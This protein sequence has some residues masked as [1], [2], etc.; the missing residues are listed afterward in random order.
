MENTCN[1]MY[2]YDPKD[3][4]TLPD[5]YQK[6]GDQLPLLVIVTEGFSGGGQLTMNYLLIRNRLQYPDFQELIKK[7]SIVCFTETK[8][9]DIDEIKLDDYKFVMKNRYKIAKR[10][11]GGIVLGYKENLSK[12]IEVLETDCNFVMWFKVC[13]TYLK[14]DDD[15]YFGIVYV[16]PEYSPYSTDDAFRQIANEYIDLTAK[17]I[18]VCLLGDFNARTGNDVD[19]TTMNDKESQT[20]I[21]GFIENDYVV[22]DELNIPL[23]R[24]NLDKAKN[25][26]GNLLLE[27]CR[28]NS[29]FI[30]NGRMGGN[31][32][33]FTCRNASVVDYVITSVH[34]LRFVCNF[35][36][37]DFSGLFSDV[38]SPI[39]VSFKNTYKEHSDSGNISQNTN[40]KDEKIK[41]WNWDLQNDFKNN[42]SQERK[43]MIFE[44]LDQISS[45]N[46]DQ[47]KVDT[48]FDDVC[49]IM[50]DSARNT[51]GIFKPKKRK[52]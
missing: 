21:F 49:K 25:R 4:Y 20:E 6:Y 16:P 40:E 48:I 28:A 50:L 12:Y 45:D 29:L 30:L 36:L 46:I 31:S 38:H 34:L 7:H 39:T 23:L 15:L 33:N 41:K 42:L 37:H 5:F 18:N 13:K 22:L 27:F 24:Q 1:S 14:T 3:Q 19:Y 11:S 44:S 52:N 35:F 26:Y 51:F 32:G 10:R 8:T 9:D 17:S 43:D 47:L 2:V